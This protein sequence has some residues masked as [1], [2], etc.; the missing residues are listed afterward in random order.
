LPE[1]D[2]AD[3]VA[4]LAVKPAE[5][6]TSYWD[7]AFASDSAHANRISVRTPQLSL[8]YMPGD[9]WCVYCD[10]AGQP[11]ADRLE[12]TQPF[13]PGGRAAGGYGIGYG[14]AYGFDASG[15]KGYGSNFGRGEYGFDCDMLTWISGPLPPGTYPVK[16]VVTDACGN[17]S[18]PWETQVT[19]AGFARPAADLS[20]GSYDPDNDL[21]E[22]SF[23]QS[24]DI[25]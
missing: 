9:V 5:A 21:L 25:S 1:S 15:A 8:A 18:L 4:L 2:G 23:T 11:A 3:L 6:E 12:H 10:D 19:L 7:Q 20:V 22:L 13:F 16:V 17:E 14:D 24:E